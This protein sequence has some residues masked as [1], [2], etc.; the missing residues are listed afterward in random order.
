VQRVADL[1][2]QPIEGV[3]INVND[4]AVASETTVTAAG[5]S[6]LALITALGELGVTLTST[7]VGHAQTET[8]A[9]HLVVTR[10]RQELEQVE[11]SRDALPVT[12]ARERCLL[13]HAAR[14][15]QTVS[16]ATGGAVTVDIPR[17]LSPAR[18]SHSTR[19][20]AQAGRCNA[21]EATGRLSVGSIL[22]RRSPRVRVSSL[23][24]FAQI[25]R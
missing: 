7:Y 14:V 16:E 15:Q 8:L 12:H 4:R 2:P 5:P 19:L 24:L 21:V 3:R 13:D 17:S 25:S 6:V 1:V 22:S 9:T 20:S 18:R 10:E 11:H 23:R